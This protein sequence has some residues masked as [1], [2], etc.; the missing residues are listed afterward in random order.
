MAYSINKPPISKPGIIP[1]RNKSLTD[2]PE[3]M[4]YMIKGMLGGTM[5]QS[6][7]DTATTAVE[8]ALSYP[9]F[10]RIGTVML[11]TAATVAGADPEMAP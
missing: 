7:Q 3:A 5:T 6:H 1:E 2:A 8:K 11:P 10:P 4:P 9:S